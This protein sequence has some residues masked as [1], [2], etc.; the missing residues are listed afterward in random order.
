MFQAGSD[1]S[2]NSNDMDEEAIPQFE[3]N[4]EGFFSQPKKLQDNSGLHTSRSVGSLDQIR[5]NSKASQPPDGDYFLTFLNF[6]MGSKDQAE[7]SQLEL[8]GS[9]SNQNQM[10]EEEICEK[11]ASDSLEFSWNGSS[12]SRRNSK[13][14][15]KKKHVAQSGESSKEKEQIEA[16]QL[17]E[18]HKELDKE[19]QVE[20]KQKE[21]PKGRIPGVFCNCVKTKCIKMYC[22]CFSNGVACGF[23]C[24]CKGCHNL[25][26][27][28]EEVSDEEL[29]KVR[30]QQKEEVGCS[31]KMS[32][33]EKSYCSCAR[34]KKGCSSKCSCYN[35]KNS[36]G[37]RYKRD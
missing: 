17:E 4:D 26:D 9:L 28:N 10:E 34:S 2:R 15:K 18:Y 13:D 20:S 16:M 5:S 1:Q 24:N 11:R 32:H 12:S 31:C 21:K 19:V 6:N 23:D 27:Q 36:F 22:T 35:C 29:E 30:K 14:K 7:Q 3:L 25:T 8:G 37:T 33:C